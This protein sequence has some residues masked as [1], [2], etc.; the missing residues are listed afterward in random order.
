MPVILAVSVCSVPLPSTYFNVTEPS[1]ATV[2]VSGLMCFSVSFNC[3]TFTASVSAVPFSTLVIFLL[4]AS[5]PPV[6][7]EGPP[8]MLRP[9]L[10]TVVPPT[11]KEPAL[12]RVTLSFKLNLT[13]PSLPISAVVFVPLVKSKPLSNLTVLSPE[14]LAL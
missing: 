1:F 2:Y 6:V 10:F 13:T 11:V 14:P 8:V 12:V 9:P 4:P 5:I 7:T 3:F